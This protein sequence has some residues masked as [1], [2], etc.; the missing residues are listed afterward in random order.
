MFQIIAGTLEFNGVT[1]PPCPS[2]NSAVKGSVAALKRH[3]R[4]FM[5]QPRS[6]G[7]QQMTG[8][9]YLEEADKYEYDTLVIGRMVTQ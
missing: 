9:S 1:I 3:A 2:S 4:D 6:R 7:D 5:G 8:L